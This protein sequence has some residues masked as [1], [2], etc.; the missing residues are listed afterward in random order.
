MPPKNLDSISYLNKAL[1][2]INHNIKINWNHLNGQIIF[3]VV[4]INNPIFVIRKIKK[5]NRKI[6]T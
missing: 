5:V 3:Q 1:F 2:L 6:L 4:S